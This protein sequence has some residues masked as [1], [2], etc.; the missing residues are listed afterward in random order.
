ARFFPSGTRI[1]PRGGGQG[2]RGNGRRR[3][4][5]PAAFFLEVGGAG[6]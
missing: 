1:L 3:R 5:V 6:P 4:R 2:Q